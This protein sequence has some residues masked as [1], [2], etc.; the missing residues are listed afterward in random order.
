[1][2]KKILLLLLALIPMLGWS[3]GYEAPF[4]TIEEILKYR[5]LS[6]VERTAEVI[7]APATLQGSFDVPSQVVINGKTYKVTA[8]GN[9]AFEGCEDIKCITIP[10]SV[11]S[12]GRS[13]FGC[14]LIKVASDNKNYASISGIL[15]SKDLTKLIECPKG[16]KGEV[17]IPGTVTLIG[18]EAFNGCLDLTHVMIPNSVETIGKYA[19]AACRELT[20][21][22]IPN[23]VT[24]IG[25]EAFSGCYALTDI[26]LS[27]SVTIIEEGAFSECIGLTRIKIPSSIV[28]IGDD[29]FKDCTELR[30]VSIPA[31]FKDRIE[32]IFLYCPKLK[33]INYTE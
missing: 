2:K 12:I 20:N 30:E 14:Q 29:A 4:K 8:I 6:E 21:V 32:D 19:F 13:A 16:I 17:T 33:T 22:I 9:F 28:F 7:G 3:Q 5:I 10:N 26:K 11:T 23:S 15:Y 18:D 27:D 24:F 25:E 1:M 31:K